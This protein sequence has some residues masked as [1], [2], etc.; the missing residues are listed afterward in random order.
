MYIY[1]KY[2]TELNQSYMY[3]ILH[4]VYM[5]ILLYIIYRKFSL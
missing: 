3:D 5:Y 2:K 1:I 4:A